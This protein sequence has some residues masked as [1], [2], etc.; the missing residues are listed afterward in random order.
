L[1]LLEEGLFEEKKYRKDTRSDYE[2]T[3]KAKRL[4]LASSFDITQKVCQILIS[5]RLSP[6]TPN[7]RERTGAMY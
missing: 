4:G 1:P 7:E 3:A 6:L 2:E 5:P